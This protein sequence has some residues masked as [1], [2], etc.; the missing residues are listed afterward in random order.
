MCAGSTAIMTMTM[1]MIMTNT[2]EHL[3]NESRTGM[4]A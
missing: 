4:S 1:I 3:K 2:N